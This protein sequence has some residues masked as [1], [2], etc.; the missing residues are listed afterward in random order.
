M[1]YS[2]FDT[3]IKRKV[4]IK[5]L[6]AR[7]LGGDEEQ[8][9]RVLD[10]FLR[11]AQVAARIR[12]GS[13]VEIHDFGVLGETEHPYIIMELLRGADL[14][15]ELLENGPMEPP[16]LFP[17][18]VDV[19]D[20][21]GEAH[22]EGVVH[23]DLKPANLYL[24][25][26]GT[27]RETMKIV[28]FGIAHVNAP[29]EERITTTGSV[30]GTPQYLAPEYIQDQS[31]TPAMDI[32][33]M[34]LILVEGLTAEPVVQASNLFQAALMHV[35]Q[36]FFIPP[37]LLEGDFGEIVRRATALEP[38]DRFKSTEAFAD[39]LAALDPASV[40][41]PKFDPPTR[42]SPISP[43]A[44]TIP[45][46]ERND[47]SDDDIET[48]PTID[49]PAPADGDDKPDEQ[50]DEEPED[51][52]AKEVTADVKEGDSFSDSALELA[53]ATVSNRR[54]QGVVAAVVLFLL[55]AGSFAVFSSG[56]SGES[57]ESEERSPTTA[58][59]DEKSA[60][61]GDEVGAAEVPEATPESS[62]AAEAES[63]DADETA[64]NADASAERVEPKVDIEPAEGGPEPVQPEE[65]LEEDERKADEP[66]EEIEEPAE[67]TSE[68]T[69]DSGE[70]Q[71]GGVEPREETVEAEEESVKEEP[72]EEHEPF[73]LAP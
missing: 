7:R 40:Q 60:E 49:K 18:F 58:Q 48:A 15:E 22:V 73:Q 53:I 20:A 71:N 25:E 67:D 21:L 46:Q 50:V 26:R 12:H 11:E 72:E 64:E 37:E 27:R 69:D 44:E 13:I 62:A 61:I 47:S 59:V 6:N 3:V 34:G 65:S 70:E 36:D 55:G 51:R 16:R 32:Y 41:V 33:Q 56:S 24:S 54:A 19:L 66:V 30:S 39:A 1:V 57:L 28:D 2:A 38:E 45:W 29:T 42:E 52:K 35:D 43:V 63:Q 5:V 31:V 68:P 14:G 23:K 8:V 17:L 9:E 4:A 10:R